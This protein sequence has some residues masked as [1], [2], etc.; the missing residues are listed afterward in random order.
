MIGL[1]GSTWFSS[2]SERR[3]CQPV[4]TRGLTCG[5]FGDA[6]KS[7]LLSFSPTPRFVRSQLF[8]GLVFYLC[9]KETRWLSLSVLAARFS[10][11]ELK[12]SG[13]VD[14]APSVDCLACRVAGYPRPNF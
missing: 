5:S 4:S 11:E 7:R 3:K 12:V 14:V 8:L 13:A 1:S 10:L 6:V 9:W 2:E